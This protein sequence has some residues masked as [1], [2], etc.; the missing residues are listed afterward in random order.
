MLGPKEPLFA[1]TPPTDAFTGDAATTESR[2]S[3]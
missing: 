2:E 1:S 3:T